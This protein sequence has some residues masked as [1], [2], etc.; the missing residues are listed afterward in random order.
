MTITN[1]T[2][3][4][5]FQPVEKYLEESA[6]ADLKKASEREYTNMY[7]LTF[8]QFLRVSDGYFSDV[9][10]DMSEP[11]VLQ[12]YWIKRFEDFQREFGDAIKGTQVQPTKEQAEAMEG[13]PKQTFAESMITFARSYFGLHSFSEAENL[14][15]GELIIARRDA[16]ISAIYE[17]R[18]QA[19]QLKNIRTKK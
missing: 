8:G 14:T 4:A 9:L 7:D 15:I 5:E 18:L 13:L 2:K 16:Y 19:I 3:H 17:R 12:I 10:G 6:V 1:K 11:T